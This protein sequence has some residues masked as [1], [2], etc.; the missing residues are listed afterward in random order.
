[1]TTACGHRSI[2]HLH[3]A[4]FPIAVARLSQ[5]R[6][7]NRPVVMA[8]VQSDRPVVLSVS[9]EARREGLF[10]GMPLSTAMKRCPGLKV[11]PPDLETAKKINRHL[12]RIASHYTPLWEA[13]RPGHLF[14][15]L[16]GA[17]RLFGPVRDVSRRLQRDIRDHLGLGGTLG[18][19]GNKLVSSVA[20][21]TPAA[22]KDATGIFHVTYGREAAFM[23]PLRVDVL[24]GIGPVRR[25]HLLEELNISRVGHLAALDLGRLKL[26]FGRRA[27]LIHQWSQ[28]MDATPVH[29][30]AGAPIISEEVT[31]PQDENDDE[32]LLG[33]FWRLVDTCFYDIRK[34]GWYPLKAG[35]MV[36]YAD[37]ASATRLIKLLPEQMQPNGPH[38]QNRSLCAVLEKLFFDVCQRRVRVRFFKVWFREFRASHVQ[39]SLF[40]TPKPHG[41]KINRLIHAMD[42]IQ[43]R[44]GQGAVR[45]GMRCAECGLRNASSSAVH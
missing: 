5:P 38:L 12:T 36:R 7:R 44:Y 9:S 41:E 37:Q 11:L 8:P 23:A 18:V 6:L 16:T 39:L 40:Q 22:A 25:R 14:L 26:V 17:E 33:L 13:V 20:S 30:G 21:R 10:K 4:A 32:R 43:D 27:G 24:P 34:R 2:V 42:R 19:A 1:M 15:D 29:A 35:L 31:L 3:I 28:G 45:F